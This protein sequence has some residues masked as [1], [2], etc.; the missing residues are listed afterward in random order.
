M[1]TATGN[2]S[3]LISMKKPE[4]WTSVLCRKGRHTNCYSLKCVCSHHDCTVQEWKAH[5]WKARQP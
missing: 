5:K 1:S 2:R 4:P 3:D